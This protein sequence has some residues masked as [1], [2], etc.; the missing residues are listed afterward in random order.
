MTHDHVALAAFA[1]FIAEMTLFFWLINAFL[2]K[3]CP[4][5]RATH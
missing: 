2:Q 1:L 5:L 4:W 3:D